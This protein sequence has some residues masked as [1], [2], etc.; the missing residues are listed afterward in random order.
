MAE[1]FS[2]CARIER[3]VLAKENFGIRKCIAATDPKA[4]IP[5]AIPLP[6]E[7][8]AGCAGA[9]MVRQ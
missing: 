3:S 1:I 4:K 8:C 6:Q 9:C 5:Y 7:G 2:A